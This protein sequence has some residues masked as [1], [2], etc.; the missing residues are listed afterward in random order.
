[1]PLNDPRTRCL[2]MQLR[3]RRYVIS[4]FTLRAPGSTYRQSRCR[5]SSGHSRPGL[6]QPLSHRSRNI[7]TLFRTRGN[8]YAITLTMVAIR[9][10]SNLCLYLW[11]LDHPLP[12]CRCSP[13]AEDILFN[14]SQYFDNAARSIATEI[15]RE[16]TF[17]GTIYAHYANAKCKRD[18]GAT[19][20]FSN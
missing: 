16:D 18:N 7:I 17:P 1:M 15:S 2:C 6:V 19:R 10:G 3:M 4:H 9:V 14:I 13:T 20:C 12:T 8:H 11:C 5:E